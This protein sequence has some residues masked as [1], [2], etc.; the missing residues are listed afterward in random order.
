MESIEICIN[1]L[2]SEIILF[3]DVKNSLVRFLN[4]EKKIERDLID[5]LVRI[6]RNWDREYHK[7]NIIDSERFLI[8]ITTNNGVDIIKGSGI[9]PDNY[10]A[11][12][13]LVGKI[14]E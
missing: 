7:S 4:K 14:Y 9:Y 3:I 10:N 2:Y 12:K 6:I 5:E 13:E 11:F 1:N 8:K